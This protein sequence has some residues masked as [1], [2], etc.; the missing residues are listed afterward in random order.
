MND[1]V[2]PRARLELCGYIRNTTRLQISLTK[3]GGPILPR[4]KSSW[5]RCNPRQVNQELSQS[6]SPLDPQVTPELP[7]LP[8]VC[9]IYLSRS[10]TE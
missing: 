6:L 4:D 9:S 3:T 10:N 7:R 5:P 2:R 1:P 8:K